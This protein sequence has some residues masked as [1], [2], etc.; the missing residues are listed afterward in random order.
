MG[1]L[2][3]AI[4]L[5]LSKE[6]VIRV[7]TRVSLN[8]RDAKLLRDRVVPSATWKRTKG[9]LSWHTSERVERLA[10][11]LATAEYVW[12]D[13]EQARTWVNQPHPELG[14]KTPLAVATTEL[15]ARVVEDL[16]DKLFYG[17]PA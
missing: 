17:L 16:L 15:G 7:V 1:D 10:R 4:T 11:I 5:G 2:E 9:R 3:K 6:A 13:Q 14:G 8:A 12:D